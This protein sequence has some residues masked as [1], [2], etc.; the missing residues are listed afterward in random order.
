MRPKRHVVQIAKMRQDYVGGGRWPLGLI[1]V[2][3]KATPSKA[4]GLYRSSKCP[5]PFRSTHTHTQGMTV[6]GPLHITPF[7]SQS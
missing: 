2:A 7:G 4:S 6:F 1:K 5:I 3:M